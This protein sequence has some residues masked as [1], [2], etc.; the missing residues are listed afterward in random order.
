M[1]V[2]GRVTPELGSATKKG[3]GCC[4]CP[5]PGAIPET[6][7]LHGYDIG[8]CCP[9]SGYCNSFL[10]AVNYNPSL[11]KGL[12]A[13]LVLSREWGIAVNPPTGFLS[14][15]RTLGSFHFS[16]TDFARHKKRARCYLRTFL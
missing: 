13:L 4:N 2:W 1:L 15:D 10:G 3:G 16:F 5:K 7:L 8:R 14:G 12:G 6:S 9:D 11:Q